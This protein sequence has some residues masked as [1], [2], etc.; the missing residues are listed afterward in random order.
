MRIGVYPFFILYRVY[1]TVI[2]R[3]FKKILKKAPYNLNF[4]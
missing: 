1:F 3:K 2:I 4:Y